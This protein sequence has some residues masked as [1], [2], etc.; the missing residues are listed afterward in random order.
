VSTWGC[1][2][3][4]IAKEKKCVR[5]QTEMFVVSL[6]SIYMRCA[7]RLER[8]HV[9]GVCLPAHPMVFAPFGR[10]HWEQATRLFFEAIQSYK[11]QDSS[12]M[13]ECTGQGRGLGAKEGFLAGSI[14]AI[15]LE[16]QECASMVIE[17]NGSP[18]LSVLTTF[19]Q[20][21]LLT[22]N[23]CRNRACEDPASSM[24]EGERLW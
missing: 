23:N 19:L 12:N 24:C 7:L 10:N 11:Q 1:E 2:A 21:S 8:K 9:G 15:A 6:A 13:K 20:D 16:C 14:E 4:E 5:G 18:D 22:G 17:C 3:A